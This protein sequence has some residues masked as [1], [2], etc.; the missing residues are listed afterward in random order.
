MF[1]KESSKSSYRR[2]DEDLKSKDLQVIF[3]NKASD[4]ITCIFLERESQSCGVTK[5]FFSLS[6]CLL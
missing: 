1:F 4:G 6:V 5:K 2:L 3:L